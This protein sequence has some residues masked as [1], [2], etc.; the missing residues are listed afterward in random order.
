[1]FTDL[2]SMFLLD[3]GK[4]LAAFDCVVGS[5]PAASRDLDETQAA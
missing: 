3:E 4:L 2:A 1:M 5:S